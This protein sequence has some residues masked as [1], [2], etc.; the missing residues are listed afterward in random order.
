MKKVV[1]LTESELIEIVKRVIKE[2]DNSDEEFQH[3]DFKTNIDECFEIIPRFYF[4]ETTGGPELGGTVDSDETWEG[5]D[6]WF[7]NKNKIPELDDKKAYNRFI[8]HV[9]DEVGYEHSGKGGMSNPEMIISE[10]CFDYDDEPSWKELLPYIEQMYYNTIKKKKL[11]SQLTS[12]KSH[13]D[14]I[15]MAQQLFGG[16]V[17]GDNFSHFVDGL[18]KQYNLQ[19][20]LKI[21]RKLSDQAF[22]LAAM[23]IPSL[24]K[25]S[26][27]F[28]AAISKC[29]IVFIFYISLY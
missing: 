13:K 18:S 10:D 4:G 9:K 27:Y 19:I 24:V 25:N 11:E 17:S 1:K 22:S 2:Q 7:W 21:K 15:K 29:S 16:N 5:G 8:K 3:L 26:P 28:F 12:V 20:P 14:A 6:L 23:R